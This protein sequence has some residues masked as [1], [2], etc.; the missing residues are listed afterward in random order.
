M[1][2]HPWPPRS[3]SISARAEE[4]LRCLGAPGM[5][6]VPEARLAGVVSGR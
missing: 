5:A 3:G 1:Q 4:P 2:S 6:R